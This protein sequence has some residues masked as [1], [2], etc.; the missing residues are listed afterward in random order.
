MNAANIEIIKGVVHVEGFN[1]PEIDRNLFI[2]HRNQLYTLI[3]D[4]QL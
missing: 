2:N 4:G 1:L 3:A